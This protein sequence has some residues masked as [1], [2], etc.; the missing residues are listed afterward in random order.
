MVCECLHAIP[1]LSETEITK[2]H[3]G[4]FLT[5]FYRPEKFWGVLIRFKYSFWFLDNC[6]TEHGNEVV[7]LTDSICSNHSN[8]SPLCSEYYYFTCY[9]TI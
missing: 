1:A 8:T 3:F 6:V 9:W 5:E 2:T 7:Q 4:V